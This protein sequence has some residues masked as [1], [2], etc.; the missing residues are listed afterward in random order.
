MPGRGDATDVTLSLAGREVT[1]NGVVV[2][3][4]PGIGFALEF[5]DLSEEQRAWLTELIKVTT[6]SAKAN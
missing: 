1:L 2:Y 3:V 5:R 4:E 6:R